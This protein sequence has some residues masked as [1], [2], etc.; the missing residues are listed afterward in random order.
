MYC[1]LFSF[2][3][4]FPHNIGANARLFLDFY[5]SMWLKVFD[6]D[7]VTLPGVYLQL[8]RAEALNRLRA[9]I[10]LATKASGILRFNPGTLPSHLPK[11]G[12]EFE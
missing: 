7:S 1:K 4:V 6:G 9:L 2:A 12:I 11:P 3:Y 5:R 8:A 10:S